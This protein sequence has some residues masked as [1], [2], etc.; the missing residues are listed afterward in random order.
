LLL[1]CCYRARDTTIKVWEQQAGGLELV[2]TLALH[3]A[4]VLAVVRLT[5]TLFAS[6]SADKTIKVSDV[7]GHVHRTLTG[8]TDWVWQ[9]VPL[10]SGQLISSSEDGTLRRWDWQQGLDLG[11][12]ASGQPPI[13]ALLFEPTQRQLISGDY[14]GRIEVRQASSDYTHWSVQ[15]G[16]TA[17]RG[18]VRTLAWLGD[19]RVAS[20]GEDNKIR[21]WRLATGQCEQEMTHDDFVQALA[22]LPDRHHLISASYDG[23]LRTWVV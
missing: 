14:A 4:T 3:A 9:V 15:Q 13:H 19:D 23:K 10:P 17:H 12:I 6:S 20:G 8:H 18:L 7:D 5:D 22:W 2:R 16:F 11:S 1:P 21:V